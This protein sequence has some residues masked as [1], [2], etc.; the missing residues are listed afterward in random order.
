MSMIQQVQILLRLHPTK[1][2]KNKKLPLQKKRTTKRNPRPKG[3]WNK[4]K[5]KPDCSV[6]SDPYDPVLMHEQLINDHGGKT[7]F[8]IFFTFDGRN[9]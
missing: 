4:S 5:N 8:E 2:L 1:L 3:N 7:K 9:I 6:P